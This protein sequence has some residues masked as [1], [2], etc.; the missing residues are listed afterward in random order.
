MI[1]SGTGWG[2]VVAVC[3]ALVVGSSWRSAWIAFTVVAVLATGLAAFALRGSRRGSPGPGG[4]L[5]PLSWS[6]FVCPRS[7]PLLA[8]ALL[9]GIGASVY[10]TFAAD[11]ASRGGAGRDAGAVLL[12]VVGVSS[13]LGGA[14]GDLLER[15]GGRRALQ[16]S[17][18]G[19]AGS[20]CLLAVWHGSWA[21]LVLS[22]ATFGATYNVLLA[23]QAIWSSRVFASR[24][25]TGLAAMLFMLGLGQI[26][27]PVLAGLLAD[28]VGLAAAFFAGGAVILLS[29]LMPPREELRAAA[30]SAG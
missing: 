24:P 3:V 30:P 7:G 21:G 27:G 28:R 25:A 22:A 10:W 29:A 19:L 17:A 13:V 23:V 14:A 2:V 16:L 5:P 12:G 9:V 8:G 6:W 18:A 15:L 11:F 26:V 1:S 4:G 20:M